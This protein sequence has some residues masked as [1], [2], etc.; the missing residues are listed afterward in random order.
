MFQDSV[1]IVFA[2][3]YAVDVMQFLANTLYKTKTCWLLLNLVHPSRAIKDVFV[4]F[5]AK[6]C[7][8]PGDLSLGYYRK[9]FRASGCASTAWGHKKTVGFL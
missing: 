9:P 8:P 2:Q 6:S 7:P 3:E 1:A 4:V 5:V